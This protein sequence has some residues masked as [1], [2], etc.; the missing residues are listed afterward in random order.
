MTENQPGTVL[1]GL[2]GPAVVHVDGN[3]VEIR[4]DRQQRLLAAL[5][6]R[7]GSV[8]SVDRLTGIVWPQ[9]RRAARPAEHAAHLRLPSTAHA[10]IE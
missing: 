3:E 1:V 10:R 8:A 9:G 5:A 7:L 2:L 6:V 4:G